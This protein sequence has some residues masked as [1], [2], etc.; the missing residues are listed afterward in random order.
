MSEIPGA[1]H[2]RAR[3]NG[4]TSYAELDGLLVEYR[5]YLS[6]KGDEPR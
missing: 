4:C 1:T 3:V 6:G 2:V 5:E